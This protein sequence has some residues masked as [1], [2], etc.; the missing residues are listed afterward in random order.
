MMA[1]ALQECLSPFPK[2]GNLKAE[3]SD[4][5]GLISGPDII[6]ILLNGCRKSLIFSIVL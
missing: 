2:I 4:V 5:E 1:E 6:A 3:Q